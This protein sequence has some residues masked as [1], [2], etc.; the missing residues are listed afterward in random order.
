MLGVAK[1]VRS[2]LKVLHSKNPRAAVASVLKIIA[3]CAA[4]TD[5]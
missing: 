4:K 2:G 3:D 5:R 1:E